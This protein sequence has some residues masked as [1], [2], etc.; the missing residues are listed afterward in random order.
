MNRPGAASSM[1]LMACTEV[2]AVVLEKTE[3]RYSKHRYSKH[4][5]STQ[6]HAADNRAHFSVAS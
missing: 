1:S 2:H 3:H 4:A 5:P 6:P